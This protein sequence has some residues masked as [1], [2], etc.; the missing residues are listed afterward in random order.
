MTQ[1]ND[2]RVIFVGEQQQLIWGDWRSGVHDE[3]EVRHWTPLRIGGEIA[4]IARDNGT[5]RMFWGEWTSPSFDDLYDAV[6]H[7]QEPVCIARKTM[8][9]RLLRPGAV[10]QVFPFQISFRV[11]EGLHVFRFGDRDRSGL[12]VVWTSVGGERQ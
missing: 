12:P 11:D 10:T 8:E 5:S 2:R 1:P 9:Y 7:E 4:Y 3:I 6:E